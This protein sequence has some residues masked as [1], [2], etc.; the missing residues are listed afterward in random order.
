MLFRSDARHNL[1]EQRSFE[2]EGD[3]D[4]ADSSTS[5]SSSPVTPHASLRTFLSPSELTGFPLASYSATSTSPAVRH[6]LHLSSLASSLP[7]PLSTLHHHAHPFRHYHLPTEPTH[8]LRVESLSSTYNT[9]HSPPILSRIFPSILLLSI[10]LP[11]DS[12]L[13]R[14]IY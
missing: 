10:T 11:L 9:S 5:R 12:P 7:L 2:S 3:V 14:S 4:V 13:E 8:C 1:R 6:R